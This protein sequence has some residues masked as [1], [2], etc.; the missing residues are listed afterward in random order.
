VRTEQYSYFAANAAVDWEDYAQN[1]RGGLESGH[2]S[3]TLGNMTNGTVKIKVWDALPGANYGPISLSVGSTS[4][5]VSNLVIPFTGLTQVQLP[6]APADVQATAKS[7]SEVDVTWTASTTSGVTYNVYRSTTSGF[8]PGS[9]TLLGNVSMDSY[10]DTSVSAGTT[11]YYVVSAVNSSGSAAASQASAT[12]PA[13]IIVLT[14]PTVGVTPAS[15]TITTAASLTLTVTV[16][17]GIGNATPTGSVALSSGS[18]ASSSAVLSGGRAAITIG[19]GALAAGSYT[20][21]ATYTPDAASA[22]IYKSATGSSSAVVSAVAVS[23]FV[24]SNSGNI[25]INPGATSEN[26]STIIVTPS[27]GFTG[28]VALSCAVETTVSNSAEAVTCKLGSGGTSSS[29]VT[30]SGTTA[31][32][33]TLTAVSTAV[34]RNPLIPLKGLFAGGG[35]TL[36]VLLFFGFPARRRKC[37][38]LLGC[39]LLTAILGMCIGCGGTSTKTGSGGTP[40]G[41]YTATVTGTGIDATSGAITSSTVITITVK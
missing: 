39:F 11:Y 12:T 17:G 25:A 38:M 27:G 13:A 20:I 16:S 28:K 19:A 9:A 35:A 32:T 10:D 36:A 40:A 37:S 23:S 1:S 8:T 4:G 5:A 26:T 3:G 22:A 7:A 21:T 41:T 18:Y 6:A 14:T 2:T 30:V 31:V 33:A 15:S 29:S 24:L 34:S